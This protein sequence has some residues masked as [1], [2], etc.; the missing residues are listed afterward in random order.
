MSQLP[1][2]QRSVELRVSSELLETGFSHVQGGALLSWFGP[3][4][5]ASWPDFAKSWDRLGQDV[6]MADGGRYRKRRH[7]TFRIRSGIVARK[8]HQPHFQS[9]DY[10]RL[11][12]DVQRWFDPVEEAVAAGPVPEA[13]FAVCNRTFSRTQAGRPIRSWHVEVHQF[14]IET[15]LGHVGQPTPEGMHRDGVDWVFVMLVGRNNVADGVT[16]IGTPGGAS[17]GSFA[18]TCPGDAVFLDDRRVWHGVTP[19]HAVDP[20]LPAYRDALVVTFT[21]ET[22]QDQA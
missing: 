18:L 13:V 21:A 17:L 1:V 12:G 22:G 9:R 7:G 16:R 14:R 3:G 8:P 4:V 15:T 20:S 10:N 6:F 5:S 19:I 2:E 11:N